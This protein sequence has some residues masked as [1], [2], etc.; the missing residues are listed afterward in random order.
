[1]VF[2]ALSQERCWIFTEIGVQIMAPDYSPIHEL[3][4]G[5]SAEMKIWS[6]LVMVEKIA[7]TL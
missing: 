3:W 7:I 1:M 4:I 6:E 2:W 5:A